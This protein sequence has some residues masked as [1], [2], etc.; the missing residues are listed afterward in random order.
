MASDLPVPSAP[1]RV[2]VTFALGR[3]A[4]G[5]VHREIERK[6]LVRGDGWRGR[7]EPVS[8]RQGYLARTSDRVVRVRVAGN[9]GLLTVKIKSGVISRE[10][11]EYSVPLEDAQAML[12]ALSPG[13]II[14]KYRY[15]FEEKGAVWEVDEF[16]GAN[17]G[18]IVAEI[19]L[20]SEDQ[21]FEKPDWLGDEVSRL[22]RY[23]NVELA[24]NPY[25]TWD[26]EKERNR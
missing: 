6:F 8:Y 23:L 1:V 7:A 26:A 3:R 15:T 10:E 21:E 20:K 11:F 18:L 19:E 12:S 16:L 5:A 22:S 17:S 2:S 9:K 4:G 25:C 13:E 14:E 24:Q